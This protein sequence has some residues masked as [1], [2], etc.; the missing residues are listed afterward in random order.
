[1]RPQVTLAYAQTLDGYIAASDG[2]SRWISGQ[3]SL[4]R[5]HMLRANHDAIMVGVGTVVAD[6]P[7]LNVRLVQGRDPIRVIIDGHLSIP[8][9]SAVLRPEAASGTWLICGPDADVMRRSAL[10]QR[11]AVVLPV[12]A[13]PFMGGVHLTQ[14]LSVLYQRGIRSIMLEGG[15]RLITS[16]IRTRLVDRVAITIAPKLLGSGIAPIG[17]I[18]ISTMA[19]ALTLTNVQTHR[20]DDDIWLEGALRYE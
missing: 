8:D 5:T 17:S 20:L 14:A 7:R 6:N 1:M 12:G 19:D 4:M 11:G 13:D 3:A 15:S 9:E 18:G 10:S 16:M 2:S